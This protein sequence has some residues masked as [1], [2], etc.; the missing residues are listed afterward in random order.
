MR[1]VWKENGNVGTA[2]HAARYWTV[3][4]NLKLLH[5]RAERWFTI[6]DETPLSMAAENCL[7]ASRHNRKRH[8]RRRAR[9][10]H[11]NVRKKIARGYQESHERCIRRRNVRNSC[12]ALQYL[13]RLRNDARGVSSKLFIV[14]TKY[15]HSLEDQDYFEGFHAEHVA[16]IL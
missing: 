6:S 4:L 9:W 16:A 3:L 14:I 7:D 15:K 10:I 2:W 8:H 12:R 13:Q 11:D 5:R 1:F